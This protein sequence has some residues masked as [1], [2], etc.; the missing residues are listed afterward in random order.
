LRSEVLEV[1]KIVKKAEWVT[2]YKFV[3]FSA[4]KNKSAKYTDRQE[5][6]SWVS[7]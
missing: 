6:K 7:R 5:N 3:D 4:K 1:A 2:G